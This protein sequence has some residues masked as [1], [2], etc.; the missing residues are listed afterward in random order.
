MQRGKIKILE[1]QTVIQ[2]TGITLF[3]LLYALFSHP[4]SES[5]AWDFVNA[6]ITFK[7][8]FYFSTFI[9]FINV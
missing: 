6:F 4:Q 5:T 1:A 2:C 8:F 7:T 9:T 3:Y